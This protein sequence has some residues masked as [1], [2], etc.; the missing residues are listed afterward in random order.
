M[1]IHGFHQGQIKRVLVMSKVAIVLTQ[2]FADWEYALIAGTGGSFYGLDVQY[3]APEAGEICSQGGLVAI[4]LRN[5]DEISTWQPEALVVVGGEI[6]ATDD[7]PDVGKILKAQHNDGGVVAGICG[8]TLAL[9]RTG[10][11]NEIPHTSNDADF[12]DQ[13]AAGYSGSEHYCESASAISR[14]RVITAPG[15]APVSFTAAV[16]ES[17]GLDQET[18]LQFK[19]MMAAEHE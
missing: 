15:T 18:V 4:V 11:L 2:R 12:L 13:N 6:W 1:F 8:G 17:I 10:L 9:A 3:F 7:A 16:F 19:K 5:L 14:G